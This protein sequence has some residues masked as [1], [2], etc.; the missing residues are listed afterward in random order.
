MKIAATMIVKN[1]SDII[2]HTLRLL[3]AQVDMVFMCDN[4][5]TDDTVGI[6]KSLKRVRVY[7]M[8]GPYDHVEGHRRM[9]W[10]ARH[11]DW[12]VPVDGDE[13]WS[14]I[15]FVKKINSHDT[16][17]VSKINNFMMTRGDRIF[18]FG[19]F[20]YYKTVSI[21]NYPRL[22]FRPMVDG[23]VRYVNEGSHDNGSKNFCL[24]EKIRI[25]HY[26]MRSKEQYLGKIKSG[27]GGILE[28][29]VCHAAHHWRAWHKIIE[30][31]N[32]DTRMNRMERSMQHRMI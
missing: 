20:P 27:Y 1:E 22:I 18:D 23:K 6:A 7:S 14:N 5:S 16:V 31:G 19:N 28:R 10:L 4:G 17:K 12:V 24:T 11:F 30:S 3:L 25:D 15:G 9:I 8:P 21:K 29:K 32:F 26:P 13:L 2:G